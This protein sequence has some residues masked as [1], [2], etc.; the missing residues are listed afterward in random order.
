MHRMVDK[1]RRHSHS[2]LRCTRATPISVGRAYNRS[3]ASQGKPLR[4]LHHVP[5]AHGALL[6][7]L[8]AVCTQNTVRGM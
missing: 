1:T 8:C 3:E 4:Q 7:R 2:R 5:T 6:A